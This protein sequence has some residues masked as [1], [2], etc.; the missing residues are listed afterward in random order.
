MET[1]NH[2][3]DQADQV[4]KENQFHGYLG[5]LQTDSLK[6]FRDVSIP[7]RKLESWKNTNIAPFLKS[8]YKITRP[9]SI[10]ETTEVQIKI[11]QETESFHHLYFTNGV[12][13]KNIS[14]HKKN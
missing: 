10:E 5:K 3:I 6:V 2:Y 11:A 12:Y 1:I 8:H 14:A 13:Q 7:T 9:S 4:A